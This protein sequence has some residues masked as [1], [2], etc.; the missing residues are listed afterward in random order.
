MSFAL[1][2]NLET[3]PGTSGRSQQFKPGRGSAGWT[4]KTFPTRDEALRFM[5]E[6][7]EARMPCWGRIERGEV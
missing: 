1:P 4:V 5:Q 2:Y 6:W 3:V 7:P